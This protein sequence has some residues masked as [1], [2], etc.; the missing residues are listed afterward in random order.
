MTD[1]EVLTRLTEINWTDRDR[2]YGLFMSYS[3]N[4]RD[5]TGEEILKVIESI[6]P[7]RFPV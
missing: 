6:V 1:F 4:R 5:L 7:Q 3:N 2:A